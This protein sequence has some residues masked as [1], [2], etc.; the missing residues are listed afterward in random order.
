VANL[1]LPPVVSD[2]LD[3]AD[4]QL[5]AGW[6]ESVSVRTA[7]VRR[8]LDLVGWPYV[9]PEKG[10]PP[11]DEV[12]RTSLRLIAVAR[13]RSALV[14]AGAGLAGPW[15]VPPEVAVASVST[16]RLAQRLGIAWGFDP[17]TDRG[18]MALWRALAAAL[19]VELPS[20]GPVGVKISDLPG[21]ARPNLRTENV[22][23]WLARA[24]M[25]RSALSVAGRITRFVPVLAGGFG[26]WSARRR[27]TE[28]GIA[29]IGVYRKLVETPILAPV[30]DAVEI[31]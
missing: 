11:L 19:D 14:A 8:W 13:R 3:R 2:V 27:T 12:E 20:Q 25:V 26:A 18:R 17:E 9:H 31:L 29:M 28:L 15:A 30:E 22:G 16:L 21:L 7:S 10:S 23:L 5:A 4:R 6:Y 24:L 1:V